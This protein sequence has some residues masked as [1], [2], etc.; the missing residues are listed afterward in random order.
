MRKRNKPMKGNGTPVDMSQPR[1]RDRATPPPCKDMSSGSL[2]QQ[3][4]K[5]YV[6][7]TSRQL[8]DGVEA[9]PVPHVL[10]EDRACCSLVQSLCLKLSL[11]A[12]VLSR[13]KL[14]NPMPRDFRSARICP[15]E[16]R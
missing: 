3:L 15:V 1:S 4:S 13:K 7:G 10:M 6:N 14:A 8:C 11:A 16:D 2:C 12:L 5:L 9:Y